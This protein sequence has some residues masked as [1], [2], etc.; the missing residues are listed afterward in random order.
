MRAEFPTCRPPDFGMSPAA[1]LL[2]YIG[3]FIIK[4]TQKPRLLYVHTHTHTY[5]YI[6]IYTALRQQ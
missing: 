5:I 2:S 3:L 4:I 6:Y 1:T